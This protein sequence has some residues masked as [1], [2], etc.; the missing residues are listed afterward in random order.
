MR[1]AKELAKELKELDPHTGLNESSIRRLVKEGRLLS[2]Q[3]GNKHLI[4]LDHCI[5]YFNRP[6]PESELNETQ[7]ECIPK[8]PLN[9]M[10]LFKSNIGIT[11]LQNI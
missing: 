9:R 10:D 3:V 2:V 11:S 6:F 1:T 8:T 7:V 4:N 5:A